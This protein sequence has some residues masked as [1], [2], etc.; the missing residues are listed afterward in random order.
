MRRIKF[1]PGYLAGVLPLLMLIQSADANDQVAS[2]RRMKAVRPYREPVQVVKHRERLLKVYAEQDKKLAKAEQLE[3][4]KQFKEAVEICENVLA[5]LQQELAS[6]NSHTAQSRLDMVRNKIAAIKNSWG[7][8][9]VTQTRHAIADKR[10]DDGI[11]LATQ[12]A[13]NCCACSWPG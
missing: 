8:E 3:Q 12:A 1:V 10:F 5:E 9:L 11:S 4:K 2:L 7:Q 6:V 13:E